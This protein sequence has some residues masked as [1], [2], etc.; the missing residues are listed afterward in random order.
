M[1]GRA[2]TWAKG[3]LWIDELGLHPRRVQWARVMGGESKEGCPRPHSTD[4]QQR[5]R[6]TQTRPVW[7]CHRT[8]AP[9][10]PPGTTPGRN[11]RQSAVHGVVMVHDVNGPDRGRRVETKV[12]GRVGV[13]GQGATPSLTIHVDFCVQKLKEPKTIH[14]TEWHAHARNFRLLQRG[15]TPNVDA[16]PTSIVLTASTGTALGGWFQENTETDVLVECLGV[17]IAPL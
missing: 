11:S 13:L 9:L 5:G 3:D 7:D 4:P 14:G 15:P 2:R 17:I 1:E 6:I 16:C 10:T 8:A 12:L